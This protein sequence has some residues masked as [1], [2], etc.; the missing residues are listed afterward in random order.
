MG[1]ALPSFGGVKIAFA[2]PNTISFLACTL[3]FQ[4]LSGSPLISLPMLS[5]RVSGN[6]KIAATSPVARY[7]ISGA[8]HNCRESS[9]VRAFVG[10]EKSKPSNYSGFTLRFWPNEVAFNC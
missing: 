3:F 10:M 5:L 4:L 7:L 2:C 9:R 8:A 6:L 1:L